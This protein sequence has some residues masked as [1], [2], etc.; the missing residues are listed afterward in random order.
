[1]PCL[2]YRLLQIG[3]KIVDAKQK[4]PFSST[5][6]LANM[7]DFWYSSRQSVAKAWTSLPHPRSL[8]KAIAASKHE[9]W[10]L[11]VDNISNQ[12]VD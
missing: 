4:E 8:A 10:I 9:V 5:F 1:M 6:K 7:S 2:I 3:D 12:D 11:K